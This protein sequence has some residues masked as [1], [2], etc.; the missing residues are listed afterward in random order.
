MGKLAHFAHPTDTRRTIGGHFRTACGRWAGFWSFW[1][2]DTSRPQPPLCPKCA[3]AELLA[4][5]QERTA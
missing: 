2:G 3:V 4:E 5:V 1:Y